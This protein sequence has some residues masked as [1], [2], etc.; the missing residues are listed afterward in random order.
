ME[1]RSFITS[2]VDKVDASRG[3]SE[4]FSSALEGQIL[5][6]VNRRARA[7]R[8]AEVAG[9]IPRSRPGGFFGQKIEETNH[10][11]AEIRA[12]S[13]GGSIESHLAQIHKEDDEPE[14]GFFASLA[15]SADRRISQIKAQIKES[16]GLTQDDPSHSD[17]KGFIE[18]GVDE[19]NKKIAELQ[20]EIYGVDPA[21]EA[22]KREGH[23]VDPHERDDLQS[24]K[25]KSKAR[26]ED[27]SL[28][29]QIKKNREQLR[30][31]KL[32][33]QAYRELT[34]I[35]KGHIDEI[36][37]NIAKGGDISQKDVDKLNKFK[38][39]AEKFAKK[40]EALSE[41]KEGL[42]KKQ[43]EALRKQ[44]VEKYKEMESKLKSKRR[45]LA[46]AQSAERA[47]KDGRSIAGFILPGE[48]FKIVQKEQE[49]AAERKSEAVEAEITALASDVVKAPAAET[50]IEISTAAKGATK[51][52]DEGKS[53]VAAAR[54]SDGIDT[55]LPK[56]ETTKQEAAPEKSEPIPQKES[57]EKKAS[58]ISA[59]LGV[60]V[61]SKS[62]PKAA[63]VTPVTKEVQARKAKEASKAASKSYYS[64]MSE[65]GKKK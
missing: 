2:L 62:S 54:L 46:S 5:L 17:E 18:S 42:S 45:E 32:K 53:A 61:A 59:A 43:E 30:L 14:L 35:L 19:A 50:D 34:G 21:E 60:E 15:R 6:D 8:R 3:D 40:T 9:V 65:R 29:E 13:E 12:E 47:A 55:S 48:F 52:A 38:D 16:Q 11:I 20:K 44:K 56:Q 57:P 26:G 10:R 33:L 36:E 39:A 63:P 49:Q 51:A 1:Y 28:E 22:R 4:D 31:T 27:L 24:A 37:E 7:I 41:K 64:K 58:E 23:N 25:T